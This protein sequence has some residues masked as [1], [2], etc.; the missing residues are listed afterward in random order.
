MLP[1]IQVPPTLNPVRLGVFTTALNFLSAEAHRKSKR[2][3]G[4]D[5]RLYASSL[6]S[7]FEHC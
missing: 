6:S 4:R 7:I 5:D 1:Q 3:L 2:Q